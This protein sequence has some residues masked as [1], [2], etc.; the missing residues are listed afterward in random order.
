MKKG[1]IIQTYHNQLSLM[2]SSND[3]VENLTCETWKS[4]KK[5]YKKGKIR[6]HTEQKHS[7]VQA[8]ET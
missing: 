2:F 7:K 8:T 1:D 3:L 4:K 6:L 5:K